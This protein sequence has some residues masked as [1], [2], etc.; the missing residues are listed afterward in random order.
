MKA[1]KLI[2]GSG[3]DLT[4][5]T[6]NT[7]QHDVDVM[8]QTWNE[9][10]RELYRTGTFAK[11]TA[12]GT[13]TLS[14]RTSSYSFSTMSVTDFERMVGNPIDA[15]NEQELYEYPGG[16]LALRRD[17]KDRSDYEGL[18]LHW[19]INTTTGDLEIDT[20][21]TSNENGRA[22]VY[23]YEK[24]LNL[25]ATTDSF[26]FS[27]SVVDSL[28]QPVTQAFKRKRSGEFDN[29]MYLTGMANAVHLLRQKA[30]PGWYG[31]R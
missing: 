17:R 19:T 28:V 1:A 13:L 6:G 12:Q 26:P 21:P 10:V 3:G 14:T 22:Y 4:A 25:S 31:V 30:D 15:T 23:V 16:W 9:V 24:R 20:Q 2:E 8:L 7:L 29:G 11:E 5:F 27:D 18:P